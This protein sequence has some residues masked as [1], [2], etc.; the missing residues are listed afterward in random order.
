[1]VLIPL[2]ALPFYVPTLIFGASALTGGADEAA[3]LYYLAALS[4]FWA[5]IGPYAAAGAL[6]APADSS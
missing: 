6:K 4:A 2:L 3:S 5:A 1:G